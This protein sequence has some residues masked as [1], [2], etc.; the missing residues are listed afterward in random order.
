MTSA[1]AR[2]AAAGR[3]H[4]AVPRVYALLR[5]AWAWLLGAAA[6]VVFVL[7]PFVV[8]VLGA[9]AG[10]RFMW[11]LK[12]LGDESVYQ[13][14]VRAGSQGDWL[15]H[16]PYM[17]QAPPRILMY[18]T[19]LAAGQV[20]RLAHLDPLVSYA[21]FH[22]ATALALYAALLLL[23][24][25]VLRGGARGWFVAF[26][27]GTSG[28]YWLDALLEAFGGS[29]ASLAWMAMPQLGGLTSALMGAHETLGTTGQ[30]L[31]FAGLLGSLRPASPRRR[32][33]S[34][35]LLGAG[36][37]LVGLTLAMVLPLTIGV[38]GLFGLWWVLR[39][40]S[41]AGRRAALRAVAPPWGVLALASAPFVIYYYW[42]FSY[43]PWSVSITRSLDGRPLPE[44]AL[45]W[46]VLLP[47]AW[48]GW[49][50][51][52]GATRPL[53]VLLALW[54]AC[55]SVGSFLPFWQSPRFATG[56][57]V[58]V[59]GLF[60][61]GLLE[62][63]FEARRLRR[64]L[65]AVSF[66]AVT[67][68]LFLLT[69]LQPGRADNLYVRSGEWRASEWLAAHARPTDVVLAPR[70]FSNRLPARA[71]VQVVFGHVYLTFDTAVR[72][73]QVRTFYAVDSAP[74]ARLRALRALE[75]TLVVFDRDD[76]EDGTYD[77]GALPVLR[78]V[79]ADADVTVLR[80]AGAGRA[81]GAGSSAS[82]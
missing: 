57:T 10:S 69:I 1:V 74:A 6:L 39:A 55:A 51:A 41:G 61:L 72:E 44:V 45:M 27:L 24:G 25:Q 26:A 23:G 80:V 42:V 16:D 53:A 67:Q 36:V 31:A 59:G 50:T 7:A 56:I 62:R 54:C 70:G 63:G 14:A 20:G 71:R 13:T 58:A 43:G 77:P 81:A 30:V 33:R 11:T 64:L 38:A 73:R 75:A 37:A 52:G 28:L 66:G 5:A 17:V 48:W 82:G 49:R 78:P 2:R 22:A 19:Y 79:Y 8:G 32:A 60:C 15:W 9:P 12:P 46:G 3:A 40:P 34:L 21:L 65:I 47:L 35:G 4:R 76:P 29:P 18:P 68:Y